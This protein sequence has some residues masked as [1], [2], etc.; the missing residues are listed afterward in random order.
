MEIYGNSDGPANVCGAEWDNFFVLII[1]QSNFKQKF[2]QIWC[3]L[4]WMF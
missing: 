1:Y 3:V 4:V 2:G